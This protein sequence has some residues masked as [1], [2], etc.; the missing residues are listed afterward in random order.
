MEQKN[1]RKCGSFFVSRIWISRMIKRNFYF[2][3]AIE[4]ELERQALALRELQERLDTSGRPRGSAGQKSI[5]A[6]G[7]DGPMAVSSGS[8]SAAPLASQLAHTAVFNVADYGALA[9]WDGVRGTDDSAAI[10]RT[11]AALQAA[12]GGTMRFPNGTYR[13]F[14]DGVNAALGAFANCS[15]IN[16]DW[17]GATIVVDRGFVHDEQVDLFTFAACDTIDFGNPTVSCTDS[18]PR[19]QRTARGARFVSFTRGCKAIRAG[20]TKATDLRTVWDFH[21]LPSEP[22]S[23]ASQGIDLGFTYAT[24]CGYVLLASLSGNELK[25]T[26]VSDRCGRSYFCTGFVD[27]QVHVVSRNHEASADCLIATDSGFGADGL[28]LLYEDTESITADASIDGVRVEFQ[29]GDVY[30]G[31]HRNLDVEIRIR[32]SATAYQGYGFAVT[33]VRRDDK[34]DPVDRGHTLTGLRVHGSIVG[35]NASQRT[36]NICGTGKWGP[37]ENLRNIT[38]E[39][40][41]L[42]PMVGQPTINLAS[43]K[44]IATIRRVRCSAQMNIMGNATGRI[45]CESVDCDGSLTESKGDSSRVD[46]RS[47]RFGSIAN[48]SII[49][50]RFFDCPTAPPGAVQYVPVAAISPPPITADQHDYNPSG[51]ADASTLLLSARSPC[52]ITGLTA[53]TCHGKPVV[54]YNDGEF[55]ITLVQN[56]ESSAIPNRFLLKGGHDLVLAPGAGV[57]L[58]HCPTGWLDVGGDTDIFF[59]R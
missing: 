15:G 12:G 23:Y 44:D 37:R 43:L 38:I 20:I 58:A 3:A 40:L 32:T 9:N 47:C 27:H 48:Q 33:K 2:P 5:L 30:V 59:G 34:P 53:S 56:S 13:V 42:G 39:D 21:R 26:V 57:L 14:S 49:N 46:Y 55:D 29:E 17:G 7:V 18:Q 52:S 54:A 31:T 22:E 16:F 45:V 10:R 24:K 11:A 50:K 6:Q 25:A 8:E 4:D 1:S 35:G 51:L 36:L 28:K 19:F 41:T